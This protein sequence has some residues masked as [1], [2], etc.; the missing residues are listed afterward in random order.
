MAVK[1][2][3]PI[4]PD[5]ATRDFYVAALCKLDEADVPYVV[6]GGY[7]MAYYTGIA[8]N[9]KDLDI[10]LRPR[11]R[12]R[13]LTTLAAAGYRTEFFYPFWI[14]KAIDPKT[15]AFIDILY[16]SGNGLCTVDDAWFENTPPVR[17]HGHPARLVPAEEQLW[18]KAFVQDRDRF[19]GADVIHLIYGQADSLNWKRLLR[20]F[21]GHERVLLAHVLLFGY[22]YPHDRDRV[23]AWVISYLHEAVA[24]EPADSDRVC[25]GT[26]LAQRS[27]G[28][29]LRDWGYA[30]GR[31]QPHGGPLNAAELAQLPPP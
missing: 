5:P 27:Y 1:P 14:A 4:E 19:D 6:G 23:P 7:A 8:R 3:A 31:L 17:I 21:E 20:R 26:F 13:A 28:T 9:T 16:S 22:A 2:A 29:A 11:D 10:F 18:S 30:D 25:R 15:E 12:D 24:H